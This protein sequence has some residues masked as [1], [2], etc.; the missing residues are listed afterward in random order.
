MVDYDNGNGK[1]NEPFLLP[2][3]FQQLVELS[4]VS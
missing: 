2:G 1:G 4:W 3:K